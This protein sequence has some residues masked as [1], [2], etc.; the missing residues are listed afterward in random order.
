VSVDEQIASKELKELNELLVR[1]KEVQKQLPTR[2]EFIALVGEITDLVELKQELMKE[3]KELVELKKKEVLQVQKQLFNAPTDEEL[4]Q[5]VVDI[6]ADESNW[7]EW[8]KEIQNDD[9]YKKLVEKGELK[10]TTEEIK[11]LFTNPELL[12]LAN[13]EIDKKIHPLYRALLKRILERWV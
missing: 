12:A 8:I 4:H 9:D 7:D 2:E 11:D 10:G 3:E 5:M 1:A 6:L 13:K